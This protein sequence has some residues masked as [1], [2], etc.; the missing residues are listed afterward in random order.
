LSSGSAIQLVLLLAFEPQA[1]GR[2]PLD[3]ARLRAHTEI[4]DPERPRLL[5]SPYTLLEIETGRNPRDRLQ[6]RWIVCSCPQSPTALSRRKMVPWPCWR[7]HRN[8]LRK[9]GSF[10]KSSV[11][12]SLR[13]HTIRFVSSYQLSELTRVKGLSARSRI[14]TT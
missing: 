6:S 5:A 4:N 12:H 7:P 14:S 2:C 9:S 11:A 1:D 10:F 13:Y 8:Q 3:C